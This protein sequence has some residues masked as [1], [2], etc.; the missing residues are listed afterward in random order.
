[1]E[2]VLDAFFVWECVLLENGMIGLWN[3]NNVK[4]NYSIGVMVFD[5]YVY[6]L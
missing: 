6:F 5:V 1:M 4:Q 3:V 2:S